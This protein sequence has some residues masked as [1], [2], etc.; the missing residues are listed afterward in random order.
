MVVLEAFVYPEPEETGWSSLGNW[1]IWF[2]SCLK[3]VPTS[4]LIFTFLFG[5]WFCFAATYFGTFSI[6]S[7]TSSLAEVSLLG[8]I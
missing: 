5:A 6:L 7:F 3:L 4:A 2:G 8:T 1:T